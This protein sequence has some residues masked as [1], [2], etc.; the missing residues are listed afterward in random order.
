MHQFNGHRCRIGARRMIFAASRSHG[1]TETRPKASAA[2]KH[3]II[4]RRRKFWWALIFCARLGGQL[5]GA[6]HGTDEC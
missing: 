3:R 1:E 4:E 2:R 6:I 5:R